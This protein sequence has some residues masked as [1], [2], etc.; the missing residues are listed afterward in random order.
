MHNGHLSISAQIYTNF[1]I[2]QT[3]P[4]SFESRPEIVAELFRDSFFLRWRM[5]IFAIMNSP[6]IY[7]KYVTG[8]DFI[9]RKED[10]AQLAA[11][12]GEGSHVALY[13]VPRSG[14]TSL[15]Q[16]TLFNMKLAGKRFMA[17][18][19]SLL[20]VR[21]VA[22]FLLRYGATAVRAA[23]STPDE[24]ESLVGRH[25]DGT[26]FFFDR[27]AYAESGRVISLRGEPEAGDIDA[28]LRLPWAIAAEKGQPLLMIMDEFQNIDL[29]EDGDGICAALEKA[30]DEK[31]SAAEPGCVFIFCGSMVNAMKSIFEVR[32]RFYRKAT[33]F[34]LGRI[35]EKDIIEHV[36]KGF[37]VGGKI[38]ER[39]LLL[40]TCRLFRNH[41]G[42]IN[43]FI[44]ICDSMS[45]GYIVEATLMDALDAI[46]AI[47]R[48]RFM[49]AMNN[50]TTFQVS[51]LKAVLDGVSKLSSS[52]AIDAY[53]LNSSANVKRL[54]DA[55]AKKELVVFGPGDEAVLED[56]LFEYWVR[57]YYFEM[58]G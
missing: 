9:G 37:L 30:V 58:K 35:D 45:K 20:N 18:Q 47:H 46:L 27:N 21:S 34:A 8:K 49:A 39:E 19:F 22:E 12:I 6:F 53:S 24:Y 2:P 44:A 26:R 13:D 50:L 5:S 42:Y 17:G 25:L 1:F 14:K 16:Q 11:L 38:I 56:P 54:K 48:P 55:L 31:A 15:I 7:D 36:V 40:G 41:I 4:R 51:M 29:T 28:M 10:C 43:H 23:A 52:E 3:P 32:R 57:K 33:R